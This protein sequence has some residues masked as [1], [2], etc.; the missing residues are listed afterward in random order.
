MRFYKRNKT[1]NV[2]NTHTDSLTFSANKRQTSKY[3]GKAKISCAVVDIIIYFRERI[4]S[5]G[6]LKVGFGRFVGCLDG[7]KI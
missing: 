4:N 5:C 1:K 3:K 6:R 2:Q 7:A